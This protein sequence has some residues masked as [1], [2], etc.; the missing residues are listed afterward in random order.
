LAVGLYA[1]HRLVM[2]GILS[3]TFGLFL[4]E[5]LGDQVQVAGSTLGVATLTGLGLGLSTLVAA[6]SAPVIGAL[7]DHVGDRWRV[8]A[9]GL[10]PGA[11][12]FSLLAAGLPLSILFGVP[13]TAVTAGSNQGLSTTLI[14]GLGDIERQSR[15]LGVLFTVGDFASAVGPP[16]AYALIP[17][18][19]IRSLYLLS[20]GL[21]AFMFPVILQS[22]T[23]PK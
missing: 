13:L 22:R 21:F 19:G 7:S 17:A 16:L 5:Q 6:T 2:P 15:R 12:G 3:S 8:A 20:A 10:L 18:V 4:L 23:F 14:G 1:A 11:A 9:G